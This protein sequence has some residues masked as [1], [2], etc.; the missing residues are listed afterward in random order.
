M[1]DITLNAEQKL[2]VIRQNEGFSCF[3]FENARNHANQ[4]AR[5]LER[6]DLALR[7]G[8]FGTLDGYRK[9][10]EAVSAWAASKMSAKTYF[11]PGTDPKVAKALERARRERFRLRLILGNTETGKP[12]LGEHDA[13]GEIGRSLGPLRVPLL[14]GGNDIG[15]TAILT[16]SILAIVDWRN[17]RYLYRHRLWRTPDLAIR[18]QDGE[19]LPWEVLHED[20]VVA[21]FE[22]IGKAGAYVSFMCGETVEPRIFQ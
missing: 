12:W 4:I 1:N 3:G 18:R 13:I 6:N 7:E 20:Q 22:S 11:Q 19:K 5:L 16:D 10:E 9:Y 15:G 21:C 8:D 2:Y 14:V 17:G